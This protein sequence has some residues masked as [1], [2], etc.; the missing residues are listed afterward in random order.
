MSKASKIVGLRKTLDD[1]I[2]DIFNIY[3]GKG[4]FRVSVKDA[5]TQLKSEFIGEQHLD[6]HLVAENNDELI[7]KIS[8]DYGISTAGNL[9][10]AFA[11]GVYEKNSAAGIYRI[12]GGPLWEGFA[13]S[14]YTMNQKIII[15]SAL[16]RQMLKID[17]DIKNYLANYEK[18][19]NITSNG[20][21]RYSIPIEIDNKE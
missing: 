15:S 4:P 12:Y 10:A 20:S 11:W 17:K 21:V 8:A 18:F 2:G 1:F 5:D 16:I 3:G 14:T 13:V 9:S 19:K 6:F 7:R